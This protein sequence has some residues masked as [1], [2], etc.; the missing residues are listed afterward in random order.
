MNFSFKRVLKV[1]Y[2]YIWQTN[3]R[4]LWLLLVPF[5]IAILQ[6]LLNVSAFRYI[7]TGDIGLSLFERLDVFV[8]G[9]GRVFTNIN[10]WT[11]ISFLLIAVFQ[12]SAIILLLELKRQKKLERNKSIKQAG[13][14]GL[15][16][17]GAGCVACGGSLIAPI[18]SLLATNVSISLAQSLGDILLL[19]AAVLSFWALRNIATHPYYGGSGQ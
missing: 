18:L 10:D 16:I 14:M 7:L 8:D 6:W 17:I 12:A 15:S 5:F 11:P 19:M 13:S 9:V 2:K 3:W 1:W 4:Y